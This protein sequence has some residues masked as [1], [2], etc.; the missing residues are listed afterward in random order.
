MGPIKKTSSSA[1]VSDPVNDFKKEV[2]T[3]YS[4]I[5]YEIA[6]SIKDVQDG[7]ANLSGVP[8]NTSAVLQ[9]LKNLQIM[10]HNAMADHMPVPDP[11][12]ELPPPPPPPP[13]PESA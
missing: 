6:Q 3:V 4:A 11:M 9:R 2:L 10:I 1:P 8:N 5:N 12:P 7:S 13:A